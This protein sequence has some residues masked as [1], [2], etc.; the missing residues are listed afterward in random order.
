LFI[1]FFFFCIFCFM[2]AANDADEG[3][4]IRI[5]HA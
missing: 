5:I 1:I 2:S 4:I 3:H